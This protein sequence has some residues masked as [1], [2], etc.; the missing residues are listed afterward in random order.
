MLS[1]KVITRDS[2]ANLTLTAKERQ[3]ADLLCEGKTL[4]EVA[5]ALNVSLGGVKVHT[6]GILRK[7]REAGGSTTTGTTDVEPS[8]LSDW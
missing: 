3:I 1:I 2:I 6:G 7:Y 4:E 8:D 5:T